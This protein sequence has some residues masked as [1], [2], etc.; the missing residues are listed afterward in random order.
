MFLEIDTQAKEQDD[1]QDALDAVR[2]VLAELGVAER[3]LTADTYAD[4]VRARRS[5]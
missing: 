4:A 2:A 1:L 5:D 3:D